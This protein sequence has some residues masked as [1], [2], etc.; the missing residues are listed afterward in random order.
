MIRG[1]KR[2]EISR[3]GFMFKRKKG[4]G[5]SEVLQGHHL[6]FC[7]LA[8]EEEG[9]GGWRIKA[10]KSR[11]SVLS[12]MSLYKLHLNE[13]GVRELHWHV[14]ADELGYCL[15]GRLVVSLYHNADTRASF[16]VESGE[17]FFIPSGALHAIENI[18]SCS[19]E[20]LLSFSSDEPEEFGIARTLNVFSNAV[21]GNTWH[22][23]EELFKGFK[24]SESD[25]FAEVSEKQVEVRKEALYTSPFKYSLEAS[26]PVLQ[27]KG[28]SARMAR[29]NFWPIL[30]RQALYSLRITEQGM[31]EPHWHPETA[32]LGYVAEGRGKMSI[33]SPSGNIDT[34]TMEAGD[35]Y[36]IPK[37]YPHHIENLGD[38]LLHLL[39]FFDKAMPGDIGLTGSLRSFSEEVLAASTKNARNFFEKLPIYYRDLFIVDKIN[40]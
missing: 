22:V 33:L 29:Q 28:G 20:V 36:F 26:Q 39:I 19:A 38:D 31:R 32:E 16:V 35:I 24:R 4:V 2:C 15:N 21:L 25:V 1:E 17:A 27:T 11:F 6:R 18:G 37:A 30:Q 3:Y 34:Y 7:D 13:K 5:M 14:N 40:E 23:S 8:H 12:G 9:E 10:S